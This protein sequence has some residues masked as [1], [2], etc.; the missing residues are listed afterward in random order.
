MDI[1]DELI[2]SLNLTSIADVRVAL[3]ELN[4]RPSKSLGQNF[5]IDANILGIILKTADLSPAGGVLEIG[6]G[7]GTLTEALAG[8]AGHVVTIEKD[9]RLAEFLKVRLKPYKNIEFIFED[10][11]RLDLQKFWQSGIN[12]MVANLPYSVGSALL[13]EI[14]QSN[15][16]PREIIVTLQ[17]EVA[18]RL[19]ARPGVNDYGLLSIWCHLN[20]EGKIQKKVSENCFYPR[21][22]VKSAI[23]RLVRRTQYGMNPID[24]QYFFKLT[25][26]AF[27]RRRKQLQKILAQAPPQFRLP[28]HEL[29]KIFDEIE[30]TPHSRPE[31]LAVSQWVHLA[32]LLYRPTTS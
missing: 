25:K 8:T 23:V 29:K 2:Q 15:Y 3:D 32:N 26:Y 28:V 13:A 24:R 31:V 16:R 4:L 18:K 1:S 14:F 7:L 19:I 12:K 30:V 5:L 20:Y 17:A 11:L 22:D 9:K 10:V 27:S 6:A 21:P